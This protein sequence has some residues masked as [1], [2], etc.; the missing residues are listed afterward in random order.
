MYIGR[1]NNSNNNNNNYTVFQK[2]RNPETFYYNFCENWFNINKIGYTQPAYD[3]IKLQYYET[4]AS[5]LK[6][7]MQSL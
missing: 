2:N 1:F 7:A 4:L 6:C 3:V 5:K